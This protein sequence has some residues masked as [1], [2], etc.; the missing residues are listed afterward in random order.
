M[1]VTPYS[2]LGCREET[3]DEEHYVPVDL[4]LLHY[5]TLVRPSLKSTEFNVPPRS[6]FREIG[7]HPRHYLDE[8]L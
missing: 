8:L 7:K 4:K 2:M 5:H 6:R 3:G 1:N